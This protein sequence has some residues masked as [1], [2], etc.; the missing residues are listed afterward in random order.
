VE[1]AIRWF[2]RYLQSPDKMDIQ[3]PFAN[4]SSA[5]RCLAQ[6]LLKFKAAKPLILALP[7][8]GVPVAFEV[9]L[10]LDADLD[11]LLVR[12]LGAP[13]QPEVGIGAIIDG[14]N[15]QVVL[16]HDIVRH[17]ALPE[18]YIHNEAHRQLREIERRREEYLGDAVPA[19]IMGRTVIVV[20]DGVA[21]GGTIRAALQALREKEPARLVLAVPVAPRD[22]L[23]SLSS[24]CDEVVCL[25]T[26]EPFYA[27]GA[28]YSDFTQTNDEEVKR[29]LLASA[30]REPELSY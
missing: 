17:L 5:G 11:L 13:S 18:G 29:L 3:L 30:N 7:R 27:V 22:A 12:K 4:R 8:G 6:A 19:P 1:E 28:H 24:E 16:N 25:A 10:E 15:P 2:D 14:E 20:D 26:P 9:A 23:A 21:T